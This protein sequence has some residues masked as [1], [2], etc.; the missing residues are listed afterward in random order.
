MTEMNPAMGVLVKYNA[1]KLERMAPLQR[2]KPISFLK[3]SEKC[4]QTIK[5]N[6]VSFGMH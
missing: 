5:R 3:N 2:I 1:S 4:L 6:F